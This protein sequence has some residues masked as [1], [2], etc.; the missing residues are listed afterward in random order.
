[1]LKH[2][3]LRSTVLNSTFGDLKLDENG[4]VIEPTLDKDQVAYL[5][6]A[7]CFAKLEVEKES[8]VKEEAKETVETSSEVEVEEEETEE[9]ELTPQQR[10]ALTRKKNA[11]K[12]KAAK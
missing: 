3:Y 9:E 10:A 2:T 8:K 1:M 12:K 7:G 6:D 11:E 4:I 5:V